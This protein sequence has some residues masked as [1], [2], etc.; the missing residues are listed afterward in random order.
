MKVPVI[1]E[2]GNYFRR[3]MSEGWPGIS[4]GSPPSQGGIAI[5]IG[6]KILRDGPDS[7]PH[8]IETPLP[9]VTTAMAKACPGSEFVDGCNF[10]PNE[11]DNF[12]TEL[13]DKDL[14]PESSLTAAK[15]GEPAAKV[16]SPTT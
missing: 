3:V 8:N 4:S 5:K 15:N 11:D 13:F 12:V 7:V 9:W 14:N 1:G 10:F 6:L 2:N 16:T